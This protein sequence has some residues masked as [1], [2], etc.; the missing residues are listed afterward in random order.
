MNIVRMFRLSRGILNQY[1]F[2]LFFGQI[3][4]IVYGN[5]AGFFN[6]YLARKEL[7]RIQK[8]IPS[9]HFAENSRAQFL[10]ENGYL[11]INKKV[12]ADLLEEIA[13]KYQLLL[14][15]DKYS[16]FIGPRVKEAARGIAEPM[17]HI[18][19]LHFLLTDEVKQLVEGYYQAHFKVLHVRCWRNNNVNSSKAHQDVYSNLWHNDQDPVTLLRYF[20]YLSD[21]V[22]AETGALR[23]HSIP[24]TRQL[25]RKGYLRRRAIIGPAARMIEDKKYMMIWEGNRGSACLVNPQLCLHRASVPKNYRDMIQFTLAPAAEPLKD[26]WYL[27]LPPDPDALR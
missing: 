7:K 27:E 22:N 5:D 1:G 13:R 14:H 17:R 3:P 23:L 9:K 21:G 11:H 6:N 4:R 15:D 25:M 26:S 2:R 10:L 18:P 24:N 19:E 16:K 20:V 12:N 8:R